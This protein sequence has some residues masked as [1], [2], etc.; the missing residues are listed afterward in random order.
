M[1]LQGEKCNPGTWVQHSRYVAQAAELIA[2]RHPDLDPTTACILGILHDIGRREG[3]TDLRHTVDGYHYLVNQGYPDAARICLTHS[4]II[5]DIRAYSGKRDC[6]EA[7]C[8]FLIDFL[9]QIEY[10]E[11]DRLI[12]LCDALSLPSGFCLIEKRFVDVAL[13]HGMNDFTISKWKVYLQLKKDFETVIGQPIYSLLP[14]IVENTFGFDPPAV[15]EIP[16][17]STSA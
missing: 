6:S 5:K 10:T 16:P 4:F 12:Q 1:L 2:S 14:G 3:V 8:Q 11:Y 17:E 7:D 13:R 15:G 9:A